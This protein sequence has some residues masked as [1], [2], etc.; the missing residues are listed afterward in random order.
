MNIRLVLY[1]KSK[2]LDVPT[3]RELK[4][5]YPLEEYE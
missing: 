2:G 3:T 1:M 5:K 4:E